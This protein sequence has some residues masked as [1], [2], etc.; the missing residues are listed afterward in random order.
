MVQGSESLHSIQETSVII[1][2][3]M[4]RALSA[5]NETEEGERGRMTLKKKREGRRK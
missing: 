3:Q 1:H 2:P 4:N 5:H